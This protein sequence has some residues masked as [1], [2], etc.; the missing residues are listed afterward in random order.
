[1]QSSLSFEH[2]FAD[3]RRRDQAAY[4]N[5]LVLTFPVF[6]IAA[7]LRMPLAAVGLVAG[8]GRRL[9]VFGRAKA[10]AHTVIP[11]CFMG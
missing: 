10:M 5:L 11:W 6:L 2:R 1:M 7:L 9:S 8:D 3:R 4:R